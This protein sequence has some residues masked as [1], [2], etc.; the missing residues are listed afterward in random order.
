MVFK[1]NLRI[2]NLL[3]LS[4]SYLFY[5]WS[6]WRLLSYLVGASILNFYLGIY[7]EK[8]KNKK[9]KKLLLNIGLFQGIGGLVFFKYFNFFI[10]SFNEAFQSLDINL[11]LQTLNII[12]PL[13]IS[14]FTFKI[15]SYLL[16][17]DKRK[18]KPS[19]DW[20]VFF[21]YVSFFPCILSGPID[22]AKTFIPQLEKKRVFDYKQT[23]DGLRQVLWGLFKKIVI[24]DNCASITSQIFDNYHSL[25]ANTLLL[26]A[27]LFAIQLYAD[28]S[29][30]TDMATG[31]AR[32]MGFNIIRNFDY[33]FFA[34]NIAE[35]WRK[36]HIS[37]TSWLTEYVF[38]PLNFALRDY[39]KTGT[40]A[41]IIINITIMGAWHGASWTYVLFG[42]L[43][44]CYF[45]PLI[46]RD[47]MNKKKSIAKDKHIPSFRE[48]T[49]MLGTFTLV[50][51]TLI[52]FRS[53]TTGQAFQ[54]IGDL[55]SL[56][57]FSPAFFSTTLI[58]YK[59]NLIYIFTF[60]F[61]MIIAEWLQR[62]KEHGL[63]IDHIRY[64]IIRWPIYYGLIL[65]IYYFSGKEQQFIYFQF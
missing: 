13:G 38:T 40:I 28:F 51:L 55:F 57:L 6:D 4:A 10:T 15:I 9:Y 58:L 29:G 5:A 33:P 27:F 16:D 2:Q 56:S 39:E 60:I 24:A 42:F 18:I 1:K 35:Y 44:G 20:I 26:G 41:A 25:P 3:L 22:K 7:I 54:Y 21:N 52:I 62:E 37:L 8:T 48:F 17:I 63:Q 45:I 19:K 53:K 47:K 34:Q 12:I 23:T 30:Y 65:F 59:K 46:L 61:I 11:N 32:M 50:M 64:R 36:W 31:V 14:F 49:N 43:H